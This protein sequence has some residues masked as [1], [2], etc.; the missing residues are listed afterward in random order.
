MDSSG[1][2]VGRI[3]SVNQQDANNDAM[4][5]PA[6]GEPPIVVMNDAIVRTKLYIPPVP[7]DMLAR[8]RLTEKLRSGQALPLTLICAPAGY[9]KSVLASSWVKSLDWP[10][11]WLSLDPEDGRLQRFLRLAVAALRTVVDG[12]CADTLRL[13]DA[14]NPSLLALSETF[15]NDLDAL[16]TPFVLVLDDYHSIVADSA[17][18]DLMNRLLARPPWPLHLMLL[19]RRDPALE[20]LSLR[21]RG[22]VNELRM[23]DLEFTADESRELIEKVCGSALNDNIQSQMLRDLEGW[24]AGVRLASRILH[25]EGQSSAAMKLSAVQG[26]RFLLNEVIE[27]QSEPMRNWLL[28]TSI[29]DRFCASLCE[30]V[31]ADEEAPDANDLDGEAFIDALFS[32]EYF[33]IS[34]D[35]ARQWARYHHLFQHLLQTELLRQVGPAEI[36]LLHLRASAWCESQGLIDEALGH[37]LSADD[38]HRACAIVG[39]HLDAEVNADRCYYL[40]EWLDRLPA[41]AIRNSP[42]LL[43]G[44]MY[45][46][47]SRQDLTA[48]G[49]CLEQLE[50]LMGE[51]DG[52]GENRLIDERMFFRGY[53]QFCSGESVQSEQLLE[54]VVSRVS[55]DKRV[56]LAESE[57]HLALA[58]HMNGKSELAIASLNAR[59]DR[60]YLS[61]SIILPRM[62]GTLSILN[63]LS[64]EL[65]HVKSEARRM[66][67]SAAGNEST[68]NCAWAEYLE[69]MSAVH[70][71][72]LGP[73][74]VH[75][76]ASVKQLYASDAWQVIDALAALALTQQLSGRSNDA[77]LT[78]QKLLR[79]AR[80]LGNPH[81]V[82]VARSCEAR[83]R[84]LQG[85]VEPALAWAKA[86]RHQSTRFEVFFWLECPTITQARVLLAAGT[87]DDANRAA[88]LLR[89]LRDL[90]DDAHFSGQN[91]EI[92]VLQAL[93]PAKQGRRRE[94]LAALEDAIVMAAP[95]GWLRPFVEPGQPMAEL[96]DCLDGSAQTV[97]FVHRVRDCLATASLSAGGSDTAQGAETWSGEGLTKRELD[98]LEL[99]AARL[100]NKQ[101]AARLFVSPETVKTHL[102]HL[103]QKLDVRNRREAASRA[104]A[105]LRAAGRQTP[106]VDDRQ[107]APAGPL[108]TGARTRQNGADPVG[109]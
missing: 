45:V 63:L 1:V 48:M 38:T 30:S 56:L 97:A 14:P 76:A 99:V 64:G 105:L 79:L 37:A 107:P 41:E 74:S 26:E 81:Y 58:R 93:V 109:E 53:L 2:N 15:S 57:V 80:E 66:G 25:D 20:L 49:S 36:A 61:P 4:L 35:S 72:N 82:N 22:Q 21:A 85:D 91:I 65:S 59:I 51:G 32:G 47:C 31:C 12:A 68:L 70:R 103:F 98:I 78:V 52:E 19:S 28:K 77:D 23:R 75:L 92:A 27:Q 69:G 60:E 29:L 102:K 87:A 33:A 3:S 100:Q 101:I 42:A 8:P 95:G 5:Q 88:D 7:A 9:G 108:R 50:H 104:G 39:R 90:C 86:Y 16:E 71:M 67:E 43:V 89:G 10:H 11:A 55:P 17:V 106:A 44:C 13:I 84:L 62:Y 24:P 96:L 40:A 6:G 54:Q 83:I 73:A 34:L 18:H 46:A 94:A